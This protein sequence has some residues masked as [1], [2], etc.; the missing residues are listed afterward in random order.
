MGRQKSDGDPSRPLLGFSRR[1]ILPPP[2]RG[3]RRTARLGVTGRARRWRRQPRAGARLE[4]GLVELFRGDLPPAAY[5]GRVRGAD[6]CW[7][8]RVFA[9]DGKEVVGFSVETR[10][11]AD[12][13]LAVLLGR[14]L[15]GGTERLPA[16]YRW[17]LAGESGAF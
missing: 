10:A 4:P 3:I 13:I 12:A 11:E 5:E 15:E 9:D 16:G 2:Q 7:W 6:G 1:L 8:I 17:R 14:M